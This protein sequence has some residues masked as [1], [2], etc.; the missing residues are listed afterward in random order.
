MHT[1][2]WGL[3]TKHDIICDRLRAECRQLTSIT[4]GRRPDLLRQAEL[5]VLAADNLVISTEN[6][7]LGT[8]LV[9][10]VMYLH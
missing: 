4:S 1:V 5:H 6:A 8:Y 10:L 2:L 9:T 7:H 3:L